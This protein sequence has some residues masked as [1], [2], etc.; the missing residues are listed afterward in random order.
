MTHASVELKEFSIPLKDVPAHLGLKV[1]ESTLRRWVHEG[2]LQ[3]VKKGGRRFVSKAA[4]DAMCTTSGD[5][6]E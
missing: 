4:I 6:D 3:T 5:G 1:A 2:K